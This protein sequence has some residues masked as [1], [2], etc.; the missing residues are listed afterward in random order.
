MSDKNA[1][2]RILFL[3]NMSRTENG[4]DTLAVTAGYQTMQ[5]DDSLAMIFEEYRDETRV[6]GALWRFYNRGKR[7]MF[8]GGGAT[9]FIAIWFVTIFIPSSSGIAVLAAGLFAAA[10]V[11]I[12]TFLVGA[13]V[14]RVKFKKTPASTLPRL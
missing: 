8:I 3:N 11:V 5:D 4:S 9:A 14:Y 6:S 2:K 1:Q 13:L 12:P 7:I 10:L